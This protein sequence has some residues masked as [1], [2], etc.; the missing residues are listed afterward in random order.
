MLET[1][2]RIGD[3]FDPLRAVL[4]RRMDADGRS[5]TLKMDWYSRPGE[6][7]RGVAT[8]APSEE[9]AKEFERAI[10]S[11]FEDDSKTLGEIR[12]M[13]EAA[14][15]PWNFDLVTATS[16]MFLMTADVCLFV[17]RH[18]GAFNANG[19]LPP[20]GP[21]EPEGALRFVLPFEARASNHERLG[22]RR[23]AGQQILSAL[24]HAGLRS[25]D[26]RDPLF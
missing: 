12:H 22:M 3:H 9:T 10:W 20:R 26:V 11:D 15:A 21:G 16:W 14:S 7:L 5:A 8:C 13:W 24:D 2:A 4:A 6:A 1:L 25:R 19:A 23:R 18:P 17:P